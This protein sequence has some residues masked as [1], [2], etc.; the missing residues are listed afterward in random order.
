M[1]QDVLEGQVENNFAEHKY[2]VQDGLKNFETFWL[3]HFPV[4][5]KVLHSFMAPYLAIHYNQCSG[6][7]PLCSRAYKEHAPAL[8][9]SASHSFY[10]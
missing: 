5:L 8:Y 1:L 9:T 4:V 6:E 2:Q 3:W 7:N 10:G